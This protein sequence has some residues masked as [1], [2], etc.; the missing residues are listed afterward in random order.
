MFNPGKSFGKVNIFLKVTG[1]RGEYHEFLSRFM[2]LETIYDDVQFIPSSQSK[3][4]LDGNFS[5]S[6]ENNTI[7][8]AYLGLLNHNVNSGKIRDTGCQL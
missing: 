1:Q 2:R 4:V 6:L 3:F 5:C 8:R 7:Y